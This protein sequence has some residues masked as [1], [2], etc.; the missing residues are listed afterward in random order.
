MGSDRGGR[1]GQEHNLNTWFVSRSRHAPLSRRSSSSSTNFATMTLRRVTSHGVLAVRVSMSHVRRRQGLATRREAF[2]VRMRRLLQA[3]LGDG[4]IMH[5]CVS[6]TSSATPAV[7]VPLWATS[8]R[9]SSR[10]ATPGPRSNPQPDYCPPQ[11]AHS[12]S[13]RLFPG[14]C[15]CYR[16]WG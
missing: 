7:S 1:C 2:H 12:T 9:N 6:S 8:A 4:T 14:I 5:G 13:S 3:D 16:S 10:T 11:E 15:P